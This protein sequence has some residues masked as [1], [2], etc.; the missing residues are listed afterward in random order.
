MLKQVVLSA[1]LFLFAF[2]AWSQ[3]ERPN[4][5]QWK[6]AATRIDNSTYEVHITGHLD[7]GWHAYS[8]LQ[9]KESVAQPTVIK[10]KSNPFLDI[11][12]RAKE[13][14]SM[15]TWEDQASGIKANQYE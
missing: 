9:P 6:Y 11:K 14:G 15:E 4:P 1:S 3:Q 8:Q 2:S 7:A 13:V 10:F 5:I 12:G